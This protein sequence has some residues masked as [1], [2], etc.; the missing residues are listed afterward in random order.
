M[1]PQER[2]L[3]LSLLGRLQQQAN[4]PKDREAEALIRQGM[5]R[6]P[7]RPICWCRPC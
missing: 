4:Q 7:T 5:A 3:I 2:D 1:T 6:C